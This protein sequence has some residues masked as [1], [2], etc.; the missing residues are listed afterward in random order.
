MKKLM[1]C[2]NLLFLVGL[3]CFVMSYAHA[4]AAQDSTI[5][6]NQFQA[7]GSLSGT[8]TQEYIQL[9]NTTNTPIDIT[10]WCLIYNTSTHVACFNTSSAT[11]S[12]FVSPKA[13]V[14]VTSTAFEATYP[15][16]ITDQSFTTTSNIAAT[17]GSL[18]IIDTNGGVIDRFGWGSG[19]AEGT[20]FP[21]D[22]PAGKTVART[23]DANGNPH[24]TDDNI[25]DFI[26]KNLPDSLE[27][28]GIYEEIIPID[29]CANITGFQEDIPEGFMID[30]D[31]LCIEDQCLN[32]E[33]LQAE[34]PEEYE[35]LTAK[36]CTLIPLEDATI[37][38]TELLPNPASSDTGNEYIELFNPNSDNVSLKG[39]KVVT[40]SALDKTYT[41]N[42]DLKVQPGQYLMIPNSLLGFMLTN[43]TSRARLI[44]PAGNIVSTT[45]TY[46]NALESYGWALI[47]DLWQYTDR[48]TPAA[49]N[50]PMA[51][52]VEQETKDQETS[53]ALAPC[54]EG[55]YRNPET[56]RCK[57]IEPTPTLASCP[58]GQT[59][60]PDTNRC[61]TIV[62]TSN[63][64]TA[65]KEG[66]ERNPAT[67]R[68]RSI[69]MASSSLV[70][71]K[72]GQER[73]PN[74][75]RCR[76]VTSITNTSTV[77]DIP[78]TTNT[79]EGLSRWGITS[80]L[81]LGIIGY[82]IYEWRDDIKRKFTKKHPS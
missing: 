27:S 13:S 31:G 70:P 52:V 41:L 20:A 46:T 11:I 9:T 63:T 71:C 40:G 22:I 54:G 38:I 59:R 68:C 61:R 29:V 14:L 47:D 81:G 19:A 79:E 34:I 23:T 28:G 72:E 18:S 75:N 64:L 50:L 82:G 8:S 60:N 65:C 39:Y 42:D 73:N 3:S 53:S 51:P 17:N 1:F 6:I 36:T 76:N 69:Q 43:T 35:T 66:Q 12:L 49:A 10:G 77:V 55:K 2:F 4:Y 80:A 16:I 15:D 24:D 30:D 7:G 48:P 44:A 74:T 67:N 25:T 58:N 56:N 62:A 37:V 57:S 21:K 5:V 26:L 78:A 33:G 45:D 32:I